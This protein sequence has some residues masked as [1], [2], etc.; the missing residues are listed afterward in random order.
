MAFE[1]LPADV[2]VNYKDKTISIFG[3]DPVGFPFD[4][5][6]HEDALS[7]IVADAFN[8]GWDTC[9][10]RSKNVEVTK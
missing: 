8:L 9:L 2:R 1:V 5:G 7:N 10:A 4:V 6:L 3:V